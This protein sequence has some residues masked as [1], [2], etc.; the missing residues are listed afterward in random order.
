MA[1]HSGK[2]I[3]LAKF[4]GQAANPAYFMQS[5]AQYATAGGVAAY[6]LPELPYAYSALEPVVSGEIMELHHKKH[7][8]T[9]VTNLNKAL[10][11]YAD[12]ESKKDLQKMISLQSAIN[13]NGGGESTACIQACPLQATGDYVCSN[14]NAAF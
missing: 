7:H 14:R 2:V 9:Y 6:K 5:S 10:E 12:A 4:L 1:S 8:A 11:E 3:N 13:F